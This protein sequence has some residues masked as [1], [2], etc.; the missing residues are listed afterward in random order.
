MAKELKA[1]ELSKGKMKALYIEF[2]DQAEILENK[3]KLSSKDATWEIDFQKQC[4]LATSRKTGHKFV[5]P[6]SFIRAMRVHPEEF[7]E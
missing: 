2:R 4:V 5:I 3:K 1:P 7:Q 6:F